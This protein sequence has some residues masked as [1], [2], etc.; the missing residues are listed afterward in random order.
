MVFQ[1]E[2]A[3]PTQYD[4]VSIVTA[5]AGAVFILREDETACAI[6]AHQSAG[7]QLPDLHQVRTADVVML[8]I[9]KVDFMNPDNLH[10]T[11]LKQRAG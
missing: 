2:T 7:V 9:T 4:T 10:F 11:D 8:E 5:N 3:L 6:A 1:P